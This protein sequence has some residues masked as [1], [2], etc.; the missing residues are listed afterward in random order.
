[1]QISV[2]VLSDES[3]SVDLQAAEDWKRKLQAFCWDKQLRTF[4]TRM[5]VEYSTVNFQRDP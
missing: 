2:S 1:M 3:A 5:K 4:S